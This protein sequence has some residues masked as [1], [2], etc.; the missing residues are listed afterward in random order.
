MGV[1]VELHIATKKTDKRGLS[2]AGLL[3]VVIKKME[4]D[5]GLLHI[6]ASEY[7]NHPHLSK[8]IDLKKIFDDALDILN[9]LDSKEA[10][11]VYKEYLKRYNK[12]QSMLNEVKSRCLF[13][14]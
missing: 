6:L 7:G 4:E 14:N 11:G 1:I 12:V 5:L 13:E 3:N 8:N 9:E 10:L 2:K